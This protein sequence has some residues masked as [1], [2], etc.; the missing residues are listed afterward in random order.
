MFVTARSGCT[1][2][3]GIGSCFKVMVSII[4]TFIVMAFVGVPA[5]FIA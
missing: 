3:I 2:R 5:I 4:L 1:S